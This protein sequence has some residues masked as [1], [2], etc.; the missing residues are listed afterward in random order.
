MVNK[1]DSKYYLNRTAEEE[2]KHSKKRKP[3]SGDQIS[4]LGPNNNYELLNVFYV[5]KNGYVNSIPV[6]YMIRDL[7]KGTAKI[8]TYDTVKTLISNVSF[9][10]AIKNVRVKIQDGQEVLVHLDSYP[11][12]DSDFYKIV[13]KNGKLDKKLNTVATIIY[14]KYLSSNKIQSKTISFGKYIKQHFGEF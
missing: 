11:A 6:A 1:N 9:S 12:V 5:E 7:R 10:K 2:E 13:I 3:V 14:L 4:G 8:Y